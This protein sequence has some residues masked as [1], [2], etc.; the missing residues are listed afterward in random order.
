MLAVTMRNVK[1]AS[2]LSQPK[3]GRFPP[4]TKKI[5]NA[6]ETTTN[7]PETMTIPAHH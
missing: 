2:S 6:L 4:V 5:R 3:Y 1:N 7:G